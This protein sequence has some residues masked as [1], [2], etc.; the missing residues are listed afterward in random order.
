MGQR[1]VSIWFQRLV[2]DC[3]IRRQ[4]ELKHVPFVMAI[5]E[6][7]RRMVKA[8]N[9]VAHAQGI[10]VGMVVADGKAILPELQVL[11]FSSD[12][13]QGLLTALAEWCIRYTPHVALNLPDGL[14]LD[15]SGC[16]HLWGG[17]EGYLKDI[18]KRFNGFG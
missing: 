14:L 15:A 17:E 12:Q 8:V 2:T 11:D 5:Q 9:D 4:P 7:N 13:P 10:Y 16:T 6:R 18:V 3:K 1:I